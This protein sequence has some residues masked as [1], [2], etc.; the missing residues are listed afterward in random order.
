[1]STLK[2]LSYQLRLVAVFSFLFFV[3]SFS[4]SFYSKYSLLLCFFRA[5]NKSKCLR[6]MYNLNIDENNIMVSFYFRQ[7]KITISQV[8]LQG[9]DHFSGIVIDPLR[10]SEIGSLKFDFEP[11]EEGFSVPVVSTDSGNKTLMGE[12]DSSL[13]FESETTMLNMRADGQEIANLCMWC[14][15]EFNDGA[16]GPSSFMCPS[17]KDNISG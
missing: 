14:E 4:F 17:C 2:L 7:I 10:F 9:E 1:M 11:G 8:D 12:I 16:E 6:F 5:S 13:R 15:R 3:F